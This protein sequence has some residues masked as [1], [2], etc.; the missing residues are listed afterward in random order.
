MY[1]TLSHS[2][3]V[4]HLIICVCSQREEEARLRSVASREVSEFREEVER[5][6]EGERE[7]V[8]SQFQRQLQVFREEQEDK[9][10]RVRE[11][12][13]LLHHNV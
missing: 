5:E 2:H 11:R 7:E 4:L 13:E 12:R 6:G 3:R 10:S 1:T 8:R 9:H